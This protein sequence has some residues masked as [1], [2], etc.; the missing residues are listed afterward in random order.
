MTS[1]SASGDGFCSPTGKCRSRIF[2]CKQ[3]FD[4]T[5]TNKAF[6]SLSPVKPRH[7]EAKDGEDL[8]VKISII[9]IESAA[10]ALQIPIHRSLLWR[11]IFDIA[12]FKRMHV[13]SLS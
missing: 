10:Y 1:S 11:N 9:I 3:N 7:T 2:Y 4:K 8:I 13:G 5:E 12:Q 6:Q